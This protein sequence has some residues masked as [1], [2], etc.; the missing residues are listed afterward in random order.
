MTISQPER[1]AV[2]WEQ[3]LA[4]TAVNKVPDAARVR[5]ENSRMAMEVYRKDQ[6]LYLIAWYRQTP[7]SWSQVRELA[8]LAEVQPGDEVW[9]DGEGIISND[10]VLD[11]SSSGE[12][13]DWLVLQRRRH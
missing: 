11:L 5:D 3:L 12:D 4:W 13:G 9:F 6:R 2:T 1:P 8:T 10:P 7:L